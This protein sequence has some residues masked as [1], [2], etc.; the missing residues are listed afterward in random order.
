MREIKIRT[1]GTVIVDKES[2]APGFLYSGSETPMICLGSSNQ[3]P[4]KNIR[5]LKCGSL[6]VAMDNVLGA[7]SWVD[8]Y[9]NHLV[10]GQSIILIDGQKYR[11]RLP[12]AANEWAELFTG[13]GR[14]LH[15]QLGKGLS[16]GME[17]LSPGEAVVLGG[18]TPES[19]AVRPSSQR[20]TAVGWRPVLEHIMPPLET[21]PIGFEL[22]AQ[23]KDGSC[24][25]GE[26]VE[27][28][29]YDLVLLVRDLEY[30]SS[31]WHREISPGIVA[32]NRSEITCISEL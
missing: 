15:R 22:Q 16:W 4:V 10:D 14:S 6:Y 27:L 9:T 17:T 11:I 25:S 30:H 20:S 24:I 3:N 31:G 13:L 2:H 8:L 23:G 5:W 7:V 19:W 29:D 26:L 18:C 21:L 32:A 1:F 12:R 28:S